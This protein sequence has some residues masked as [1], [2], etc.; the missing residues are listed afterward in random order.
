MVISCNE[1][2]NTNSIKHSQTSLS[3]QKIKFEQ[4]TSSW[5]WRQDLPA[6]TR[7]LSLPAHSAGTEN[8]ITLTL[9]IVLPTLASCMRRVNRATEKHCVPTYMAG[10]QKRGWQPRLCKGSKAWALRLE[11][12]CQ[13]KLLPADNSLQ[14]AQP[15]SENKKNLFCFSL[16]PFL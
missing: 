7:I 11:L 6:G 15:T 12:S 10:M 1:C 16:N 5:Y 2:G 4:K 13:G 14:T 3:G 9:G 8:G